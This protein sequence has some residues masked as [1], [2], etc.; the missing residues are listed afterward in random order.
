M[1]SDGA[2]CVV[3]TLWSEQRWIDALDHSVDYQSIVKRISATGFLRERQSVVVM[4][5]HL[6]DF[7]G[8]E[9]FAH[10]NG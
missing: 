8:G 9:I 3:V 2:H 7:V 10:G 4:E 1:F 5:A 6:I